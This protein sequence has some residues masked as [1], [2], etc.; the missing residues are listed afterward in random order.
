[1]TAPDY[2]ALVER[3]RQIS[4]DVGKNYCSP[5]GD[6]IDE[7]ADAIERLATETGSK[8]E[9]LFDAHAAQVEREGDE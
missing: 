5:H 6:K 4:A 3:L 7:A 8:R 2:A 1:M 9:T